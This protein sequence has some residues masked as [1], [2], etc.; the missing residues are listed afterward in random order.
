M[1]T[2]SFL[3]YRGSNEI[4]KGFSFQNFGTPNA[5]PFSHTQIRTSFLIRKAEKLSREYYQTKVLFAES[6]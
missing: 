1:L 2:S 4:H 5:F 3:F 6:Y